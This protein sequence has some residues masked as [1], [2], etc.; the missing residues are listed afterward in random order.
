MHK[1]AATPLACIYV[2]LIV[3]ASL[4]PFAGWRDQGIAPGAFLFAPLPRYWTWFDVW[5]NWV[6]YVPLGALFALSAQRSGGGRRSVLWAFGLASAL[7]LGM[8]FLQ[9][10]LPSR[11]ASREDWLLNTAGAWFGL[12]VTLWLERLGVIDRWSAFRR[13]WFVPHSRGALV[14]LATWPVALL[15]PPAVPFGLGQVGERVYQWV[16]SDLLPVGWLHVADRPALALV[17]LRP[18]LEA[19]CVCL[20]M[21]APCWV[22]ACVVRPGLRR[23]LFALGLLTVGVLV[24]ALSALLSWGP[25]HAWAWLDE[26]SQWA[27]LACL[28]YLPWLAILRPKTSAILLVLALLLTLVLLNRAPS[29]PYFALTLQDWEQGRFIRFH[30]LAQWVG[31]CWPYAALLYAV[32][33]ARA[34][35]TKTRIWQ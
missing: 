31:W 32:S 35:Q 28:L 15:F 33:L 34:G 30:G 7:S 9:S 25:S 27:L 8:E 17:P 19:V 3:Y 21:L 13:R 4:Y 26:P 22:A 5:I 20:G 14:L 29:S 18:G 2:G 12:A 6:G 16:A 10:F 24:T 1:T 11:V 23:P